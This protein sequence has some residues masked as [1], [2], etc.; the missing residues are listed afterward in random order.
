M[1]I[2]VSV[3]AAGVSA[4]GTPATSKVSANTRVNAAAGP[5]GVIADL[6]QFSAPGVG[7]WMVGAT[8]VQVMGLPVINQ[9][10]TGLAV[11]PPVLFP[12]LGPM[13]V[14]QGDPRVGAM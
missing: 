10:S 13:I 7:T 9:V 8:R 2:P 3:L 11:G 14:T 1:S 6:M 4:A 12:P 5:V